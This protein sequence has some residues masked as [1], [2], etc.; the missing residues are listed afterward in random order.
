MK[1]DIY[2]MFL[3]MYKE[4]LKTKNDLKVHPVDDRMMEDGTLNVN[5][6]TLTDPYQ[7]IDE[8]NSRQRASQYN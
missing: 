6:H 1:K 8:F 4:S 5:H 3:N 2:E 7:S